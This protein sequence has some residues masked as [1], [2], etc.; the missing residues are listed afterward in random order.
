[1]LA[2]TLIQELE[3]FVAVSFTA[4][5][6]LLMATTQTIELRLGRRRQHSCKW[7]YLHCIHTI[8]IQMMYKVQNQILYCTL[9]QDSVCVTLEITSLVQSDTALYCTFWWLYF[10]LL[11]THQFYWNLSKLLKT[12][13]RLWAVFDNHTNYQAI[14]HRSKSNCIVSYQHWGRRQLP[15]C[16]HHRQ[17]SHAAQLKGP[18]K[19]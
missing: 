14:Q 5:M 12:C 8:T 3:D 13:W 19:N 9:C 7:C 17:H 18:F 4:C 16:R 2:S 11:Q 1:M 6:P 10:N 15:L